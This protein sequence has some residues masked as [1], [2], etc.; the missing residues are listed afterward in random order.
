MAVT[1]AD[2]KLIRHTLDTTTALL[3]DAAEELLP[4]ED[5]RDS[6]DMSVL[7]V[8]DYRL[9]QRRI[10]RTVYHGRMIIGPHIKKVCIDAEA[11]MTE[12]MV[13][14]KACCSDP[15][16]NHPKIELVCNAVKGILLSMGTVMEYTMSTKRLDEDD[17]QKL[18]DGIT[19]FSK[20]WRTFGESTEGYYILPLT[21]KLHITETNLMR[22]T[23]WLGVLGLFSEEQIER[24]HH[25][26]KLLIRFTNQND[27]KSSQS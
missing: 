14:I 6:S 15:T 18:E 10:Y 21:V 20:K 23:R 11:L 27:F 9:A 12:I 16:E 8:I 3:Q 24:E 17:F 1:Q 13:D 2:L 19:D 22:I 26:S 25:L 7:E 5:N 4:F